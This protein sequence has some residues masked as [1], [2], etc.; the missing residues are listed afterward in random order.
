VSPKMVEMHL[1]RAFRALR[2]AL[3]E[4][5]SHPPSRALR[6]TS[7]QEIGEEDISE[8]DVGGV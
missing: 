7:G 6:S 1:Y 8:T 2:L 3:G 5:V 4:L